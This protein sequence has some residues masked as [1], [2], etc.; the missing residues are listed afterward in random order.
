MIDVIKPVRYG[1]LIGLL[2]IVLGIG[3]A[4]YLVLGHEGIHRTLEAIG[5]KAGQDAVVLANGRGAERP[6]AEITTERKV[7]AHKD[8]A[9]HGHGQTP[10]TQSQDKGHETMG[11]EREGGGGHHNNPV[12]ALSHTRLVRGHLHA[13]GLGLAT[14]LISIILAFTTAGKRVKTAAPVLT[15]LGGIIYPVAWVV[16]GYLTPALGAEAAEKSVVF[17]AGPGVALVLLGVF[18]ASFSLLRDIFKN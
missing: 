13:M 7:H 10:A 11:G 17:I 16:M 14:I 3:W 9:P 6:E 1:I 12:I 2:G 5:A 18:T 4:F 8:S 15:G